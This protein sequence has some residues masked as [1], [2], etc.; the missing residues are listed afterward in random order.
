RQLLAHDELA[1]AA[2][3]QRRFASSGLRH[4][5]LRGRGIWNWMT[6]LISVRRD[7]PSRRAA[8][9]WLPPAFTSASTM[10]SRSPCS[11]AGGAGGA[12]AGG[13]AGLGAAA[14]AIGGAA[15]GVRARVVGAT[16]SADTA[17]LRE[18]A[19]IFSIGRCSTS[20]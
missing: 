15:D 20:T 18:L 6:R 19:R 16:R 8:S 5:F 14:S 9:V 4:Y 17:R 13:G 11:A 12:A 2:S 10:R 1:E 7:T 3:D